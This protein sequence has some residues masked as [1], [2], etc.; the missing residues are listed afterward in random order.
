[1]D[2]LYG[3]QFGKFV[4]FHETPEKVELNHFT[5]SRYSVSCVMKVEI[6]WYKFVF[7]FKFLYLGR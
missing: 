5:Y 1:M 4:Q 7:H 6:C 3:K 2:I